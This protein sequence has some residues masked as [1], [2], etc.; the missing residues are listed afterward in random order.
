MENP[1][2]NLAG[3]RRYRKKVKKIVFD[4]YGNVCAC[5][6]ETNPGFLTIDHVKNDGYK[7]RIGGRKSAGSTRLYALI[8]KGGFTNDYQILCWNCNCGK[9]HNGGRCPHDMIG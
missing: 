2:T 3:Q 9:A 7:S 1:E 8:I 5:C 6:G 4:Y